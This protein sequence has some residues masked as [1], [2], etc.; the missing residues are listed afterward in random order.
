[1]LRCHRNRME[2][3][4]EVARGWL[5]F[6]PGGNLGIENKS[7]R[8]RRRDQVAQKFHPFGL[9]FADKDA[10]AGYIGTWTV[11]GGRDDQLPALAADLVNRQVAVLFGGGP[12]AARAAKAATASIPVVFTSGDDPVKI[13]LVSSL[14]RPGAEADIGPKM[15]DSRFDPQRR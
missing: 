3:Q 9:D 5:R 14:N 2:L 7:D 13:G 6:H 12:P 15:A 4:A 1:M 11:E 8:L 10:D